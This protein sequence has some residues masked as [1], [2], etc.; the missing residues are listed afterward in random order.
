MHYSICMSLNDG[1]K[2]GHVSQAL[3]SPACFWSESLPQHQKTKLGH[4]LRNPIFTFPS[5][6]QNKNK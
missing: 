3:S 4:A 2:L 5:E 6:K 1:L